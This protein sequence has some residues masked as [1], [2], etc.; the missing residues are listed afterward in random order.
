MSTQIDKHGNV[1]ALYKDGVRIADV[2][3]E[4]I[5][6]CVNMHEELVDALACLVSEFDS[7]EECAL[8]NVR[9]AY[10][11]LAKANK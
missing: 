4:T 2:E 9:N 7:D 8:V 3:F 5:V 10:A 1:Y 11:I 6:K